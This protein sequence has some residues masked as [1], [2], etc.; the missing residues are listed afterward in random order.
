MIELQVDA[1][2]KDTIA[3][4]VPK[5]IAVKGVQVGLK[6]GFKPTKQVYQHVSKNN[7]ANTSGKKKQ[8]GLNRHMLDDKGANFGMVSPNH[9]TPS[10]TFGTP[11]TTPLPVRI[12]NLE[13]QMLDEKFM[14]VDDDGKSLKVDPLVNSDSIVKWRR[15][16]V[17]DDYDLYD[18]DTY[19]GHDIFENLHTI[20]DDRDIKITDISQ[21]D[22]NKAKRT[23]PSTRMER[24]W[25]IEAE[26]RSSLVDETWK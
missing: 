15:K 20:C 7:G 2:L 25:E 8:V 11:T 12:N 3:V 16:T 19:D 13:R 10:E 18:N 22:K 6:L 21:K 9:G 14:L 4:A 5:L 1:E 26:G 24:A 23:K 17:D